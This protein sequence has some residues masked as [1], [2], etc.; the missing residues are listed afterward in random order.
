MSTNDERDGRDPLAGLR[1]LDFTHALAGPTCTNVLAQM[2][3]DVVKI[4]RR[5]GGDE[6]RDYR[7]HGGPPGMS[8]PFTAVNAGKRSITLDLRTKG[9]RKVLDRLVDGADV[10]VENFRA[11]VSRKLGIDADSQRARN[12]GLIYCRISGFGSGGPLAEWTAYDHIVQAMSGMMWLNG[13]DGPLKVGISLADI[14]AGHSAA[15]AILAALVR[16]GRDGRGEVIDV[17]MLDCMLALSGQYIT[18]HSITGMEPDRGGNA[19]FKR[20]VTSDTYQT[21]DGYIAIGANHQHQYEALCRGLGC[22]ELITDPRFAEFENRCLN[23]RELKSELQAVLLTWS[24]D[25]AEVALSKL[26]VPVSKVRSLVEILDHEQIA[27]RGF[28]RQATAPGI[29]APF[30]VAGLGYTFTSQTGPAPVESVPALGEHTDEILA[31]LGFTDAEMRDLEA[32]GAV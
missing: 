17:S 28:L 31:E 5:Q 14:F 18:R 11:G 26:S 15:Q 25:D 27:D 30:Q 24:A 13:T 2:G 12:G 9:G 8:T 20:V 29:D 3:A 32:E 7:V 16:R 22:P 4:E 21:R 6:Y 1:V 23:A 19:G 10:A